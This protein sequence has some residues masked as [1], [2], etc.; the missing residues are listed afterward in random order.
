VYRHALIPID[1]SEEARQAIVRMVG[2]LGSV[3]A[4]RVTLVAAVTAS[5]L[6][7]IRQKKLDHAYEALRTVGKLLHGYGIYATQR[8]AEA[9][10]G[11]D[12][13]LGIVNEANRS[14]E[15]YDVILM[16]THQTRPDDEEQPCA[17][18]LADKICRRV[19][20]PV[21]VLPTHTWENK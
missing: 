5:P 3:P 10:E 14:D 9:E 15:R 21:L 7:E 12:P 17:G 20:I 11:A 18:S 19:R 1:C 16:G 6:E 13:A 4:C 8:V 2:Y